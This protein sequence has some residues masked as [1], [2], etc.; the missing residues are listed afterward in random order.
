MRIAVVHSFYTEAQPSGENTV[1]KQQVAALE[2]A[3]HDVRLISRHTDVEKTRPGYSTR[4]ALSVAS[5]RGP[6]PAAELAEFSPDVVH[7]HNTFPNFGTSWLDDW[8]ERS[9]VTLHNYRT[10]CAAGTLF[11]DGRPCA[12]CLDRPVIPAMAHAC[13]R[14]SRAAT[15][16]VAWAARPA[17][18]LRSVGFRCREV[19]ALNAD[20]AHT[21][22]VSLGRSVSTIPNF[23]P[24][25]IEDK[26]PAPSGWCFIGRL[27]PEKGAL[28]LVEA[29][30]RDERLDIFG[31][32]PLRQDVAKVVRRRGLEGVR[33]RGLADHDELLSE[34]PRFEG[35]VVPSMC[36]EGL[37]TAVL[38]ALAR[39]VPAVVSQLV[40][41][42]PD[43]DV[44]GAGTVVDVQ[45]SEST[46]ASALGVVRSHPGFRAA[47]VKMYADKYSPEA[48][49]KAITEVYE[50]VQAR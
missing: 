34:L 43:I 50:R 17:G 1:V 12:E 6:S 4:A 24:R 47:A 41:F 44:A 30:P 20:A 21:F 49:L 7:L 15:L 9:V 26:R 40:S 5:G 13:Y 16:P 39:G 11:R 8:W 28:E 23:T 27:S 3:G 2:D 36:A 32:G 10:I 48:W 37:P 19:I 42:A 14:G 29:W 31:D 18:A 45:A 33:M 35:L 22:E 38:E 25:P 46:M